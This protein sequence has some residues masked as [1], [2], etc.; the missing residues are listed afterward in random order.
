VC[1]SDLVANVA[2]FVTTTLFTPEAPEY[3]FEPEVAAKDHVPVPA[4]AVQPAGNEPDPSKFCE[5]AV[6]T[7]CPHA[8]VVISVRAQ[9]NVKIVKERFINISPQ[10]LVN[11]RNFS[12]DQFQTILC[13]KQ[14]TDVEL[15]I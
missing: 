15:T 5:Y 14:N 9:R 10:I 1:S 7:P 13:E 6:N 8:A 4:S 12:H 2:P 11:R 3:I